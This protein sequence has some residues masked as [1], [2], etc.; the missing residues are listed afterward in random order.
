MWGRKQKRIEE[1]EQE[2]EDALHNMA[3]LMINFPDFAVAPMILGARSGVWYQVCGKVR[4]TGD[5]NNVQ[6]GDLREV[7][8]YVVTEINPPYYESYFDG[9]N[10]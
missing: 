7:G 1:L 5:P 10:K 2:L 8:D 6:P 3:N 4:F 9:S